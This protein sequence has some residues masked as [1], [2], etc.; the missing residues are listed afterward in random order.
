MS[1][2]RHVS[3]LFVLKK[4]H[5]PNIYPA[6]PSPR[7]R[8]P[9]EGSAA[10]HAL[11]LTFSAKNRPASA[12]DH[13][14]I[15]HALG[16]LFYL[17]APP[18]SNP[19]KMNFRQIIA[20]LLLTIAAAEEGV[21]RRDLLTCD[22]VRHLRG[23]ERELRCSGCLVADCAAGEVCEECTE[24]GCTITTRLKGQPCCG[25]KCVADSEPDSTATT[26]A[27]PADPCADIFCTLEVKCL[28][29][30]SPCSGDETCEECFDI[31]DKGCI[32]TDGCCPGYRCVAASE[33]A[34][35]GC[36]DNGDPCSGKECQNCCSNASKSCGGGEKKCGTSC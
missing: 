33:P 4:L 29:V 23:A 11:T 7:A 36:I 9:R 26:S 5:G 13:D 21:L 19:I 25:Y 35:G 18:S 24:K 22:N 32:G 8:R 10:R 1:D 31:D 20:S 34:S 16:R 6:N 28:S 3:G 30:P 14:A 2:E 17:Q 15:S 27:P 12:V